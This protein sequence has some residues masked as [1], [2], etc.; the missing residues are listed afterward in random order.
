[1]IYINYIR[2][3]TNISIF[4]QITITHLNELVS[5]VRQDLLPQLEN[6]DEKE[7]IEKHLGSTLEVLRHRRDNPSSSG[8]I[9]VSYQ[10]LVIE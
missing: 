4:Y 8:D 3:L 1:M 2:Q 6:N 7:L 10:G 5:K 9:V